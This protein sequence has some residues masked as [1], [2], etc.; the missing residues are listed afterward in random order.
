M[1]LPQPA[2]RRGRP[3]KGYAVPSEEYTGAS[4]E[5]SVDLPPFHQKQLEIA[6]DTHRFKVVA[7]GRRFGKTRMSALLCIAEALEGRRAW[8]VAPTYKMT[9]PGWR[10]VRILASQIPFMDMRVGDRAVESPNGG[11][12][13]VRSADDPQSLRGEGLDLVVLEE[14]AYLNE[15]AWTE[16]LRPAL[17]DRK[18]RALFISTPKGR[19]FF[20]RLFNRGMDPDERDWKS[21]QIPSAGSPFLDPNEL[22]DAR[23]DMAESIY[24][25]EY[26]AQFVETDGAVFRNV[27]SCATGELAAEPYKG[28]LI[29]GID[30]GKKDDF[31]VITLFDP[32]KDAVVDF[33]RFNKIDYSFQLTRVHT[34]LKKWE[35]AGANVKVVPEM[36]AAGDV[37]I[38]M[39]R[40][41]PYS[42]AVT[43]FTTTNI[44]KPQIIEH[45][46]VRIERQEITYPDIRPLVGELLGYE[47]QRTPQ[48]YMAY[49]APKNAHD[50]CVVSLAIAVWHAR[51]DVGIALMPGEVV[52][53]RPLAYGQGVGLI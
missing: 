42:M 21:W 33:D 1:P 41:P 8:W 46:A 7:A 15:V 26:L 3:P 23:Q 38:E 37:V 5:V 27:M 45:L 53:G 25:Q 24:R 44:T 48:G 20:W 40:R 18:G 30:F 17:S 36:N 10:D 52:V 2:R 50:D 51:T 31:T 9:E 16:V 13:K 6:Q 28:N 43:P 47:S 14:C 22:E 29:M 12:V 35:G 34:M 32:D 49:S 4:R 11:F 19:T 39:M